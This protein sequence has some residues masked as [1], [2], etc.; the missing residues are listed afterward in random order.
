MMTAA[1][2][3]SAATRSQ[4]GF[5][6]CGYAHGRSAQGHRKKSWLGGIFD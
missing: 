1:P 3:D 6:D 4:S 5:V 2:A